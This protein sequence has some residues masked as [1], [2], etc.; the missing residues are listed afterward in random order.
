MCR[1]SCVLSTAQWRWQI[2]NNTVNSMPSMAALLQ[3]C[4][5]KES[6]G[7]DENACSAA[8]KKVKRH[9]TIE[10]P[11]HWLRR[12]NIFILGNYALKA[13]LCRFVYSIAKVSSQFASSAELHHTRTVVSATMHGMHLVNSLAPNDNGEACFGQLRIAIALLLSLPKMFYGLFIAQ[14]GHVI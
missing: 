1:V 4:C 3:T 10:Y 8:N 7:W 2:A 14:P 11:H 6:Y 12:S 13:L 9:I 5:A